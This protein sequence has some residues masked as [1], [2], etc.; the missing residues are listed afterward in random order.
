MLMAFTPA[1]SGRCAPGGTV[2]TGGG[3]APRGAAH[4]SAALMSSLPQDCV[5]TSGCGLRDGVWRLARTVQGGDGGRP[6][7]LSAPD[8]ATAAAFRDLAQR[9]PVATA[10]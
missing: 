8:S 2:R 4:C 9:L 6:A 5:T 1:D 10:P 7:V 3:G